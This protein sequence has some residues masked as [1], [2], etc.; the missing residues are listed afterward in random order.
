MVEPT[1]KITHNQK[2]YSFTVELRNSYMVE[3]YSQ[4]QEFV[5][6]RLRAGIWGVVGDLL[7]PD[8]LQKIT[9]RM[10]KDLLERKSNLVEGYKK[11]GTGGQ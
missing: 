3:R 8:N 9:D 10:H 4:K 7:L 11:S 2:D 1:L 6:E 5:K